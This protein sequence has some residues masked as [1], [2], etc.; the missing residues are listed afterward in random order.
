MMGVL[1]AQ[2]FEQAVKKLTPTITPV[3][4]PFNA[5]GL[6]PADRPVHRAV[7]DA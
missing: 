3:S 6:R 4:A 2:L 1:E 7:G 5:L